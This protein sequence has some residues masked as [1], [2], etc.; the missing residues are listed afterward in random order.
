VAEQV[1]AYA[2]PAGWSRYQRTAAGYPTTGYTPPDPT[3]GGYESS[4]ANTG[5]EPYGLSL[6]TV[7]P[8]MQIPAANITPSST[9]LTADA[10]GNLAI[11]TAGITLTGLNLAT[12][13]ID[14]NAANVTIQQCK[15][16]G[17][18][19][20]VQTANKSLVSC[21]KQ[22]AM[23]TVIVD[24]TLIPVYPGAAWNGIT[25]HDFTAQR[26]RIEH[27]VDGFGVY[28][29]NTGFKTSA[30]SIL[31]EACYVT[32]MI[33]VSPDANHTSDTP[34]SHT[35]N[36]GWQI[37]G[38]GPGSNVEMRYSTILGW[39]DATL[40][41]PWNDITR[42]SS[43]PNAAGGYNIHYPYYQSNSMLQIT[44]GVAA[45][46]GLNIHNNVFG[47]G[48]YCINVGSGT[49]SSFGSIVNNKFHLDQR[50]DAARAMSI[51]TTA[52][53]VT[54]S[55]NTDYATGTAVAAVF[56]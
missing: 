2:R 30:L 35:H 29:A 39:C 17:Y 33:Y 55:G 26:C 45:V 7:T 10:Q 41:S 38:C 5:V 27:T 15:I 54:V 6:V 23:N 46:T 3:A 12:G 13:F 47:G 32:N 20:T 50:P 25:G 31:I 53:G 37:Q 11:S 52:T 51:P 9:V 28:N 43:T 22:P 16:Q 36:D 24:C 8:G 49:Y 14:V 19:E 21:T 34:V 40:P 1:L 4:A 18:N 48:A 56:F 44:Q 42:S